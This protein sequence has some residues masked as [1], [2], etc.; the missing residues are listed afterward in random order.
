MLPSH[1]LEPRKRTPGRSTK[2]MGCGETRIVQKL[3]KKTKI[4]L[5]H[6]GKRS[7]LKVDVFNIADRTPLWQT[8]YELRASAFT[9]AL[10]AEDICRSSLLNLDST[11]RVVIIKKNYSHFHGND[12]SIL[13]MLLSFQIKFSASQVPL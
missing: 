1:L 5:R 7:F 3:L 8:Y 4:P 12:F 2:E 9:S 11:W 10:L 13:E 6:P